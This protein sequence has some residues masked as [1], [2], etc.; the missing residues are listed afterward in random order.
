MDYTALGASALAIVISALSLWNSW[1][2]R[3]ASEDAQHHTQIVAFEQR[4]QEVREMFLEKQILTVEINANLNRF[5]DSE[6]LRE[7]RSQLAA[8]HLQNETFLKDF[9]AIP[10]SP[11]TEA[12]LKLERIGGAVKKANNDLLRHLKAVPDKSPSK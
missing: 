4:R 10:T 11:S 1:R 5:S 3:C 9:D 2:A 7:K 8:M 12:R 6:W